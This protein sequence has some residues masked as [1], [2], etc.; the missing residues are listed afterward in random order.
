M[1]LEREL[2]FTSPDGRVPALAEIRSA[3]AA[4]G[5]DA[6]EL[7]P[8]THVDVYFDDEALSVQAAGMALRVRSSDGSRLATLK[9]RGSVMQGVHERDEL[10]VPL[11][12][13]TGGR[14]QPWPPEFQPHLP[15]V[16]LNR[17]E[18]RMIIT[19][20]R[21][22]FTVLEEGAPI[23]ELAFDEVTAQPAAEV[24]L[25]YAIDEVGFHEVELE[26]L[27]A[28]GRAAVSADQLA[29]YGDALQD[30]VALY[31]SDISKLE[32]AATLLAAFAE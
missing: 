3:L 30:L 15:G 12:E 28:G 17:L 32:R 31:P 1:A 5:A 26:A 21:H 4:V 18:P 16:D 22:R 29:R 25:R 27:A 20:E 9:S 8:V 19:T 11:P 24:A 10:E 14:P 13:D 2:K 23:A 6:T 7:D